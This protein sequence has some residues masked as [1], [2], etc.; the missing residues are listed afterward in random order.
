MLEIQALTYN[1]LP[2]VVPVAGMIPIDGG[3]VGRGRENAV[4]LPDPMRL[5][6]RQHLQFTLE[7]KNSYRISNISS[8]NLVYVNDQELEPGEGCPVQ[9]QDKIIIGGYVLRVSYAA[10][11]KEEL[12]GS[13]PMAA[14][15]TGIDDPLAEPMS[16]DFLSSLLA[17]GSMP[18][19]KPSAA[20][21]E[22][23]PDDPFAHSA[24]PMS[25][26]DPMLALNERGVD[27]GSFEDK[28]DEL[29]NGENAN[30][31]AD[32][33]LRDPLSG[34]VEGVLNG[35]SLDPLS[36]FG[37]DYG[38]GLDDILQSGKKTKAP[39]N[40]GGMDVN[41]GSELDGLF[42]LP[43][44]G[45]G[46][47]RDST[48]DPGASVNTALLDGGDQFIV[49]F[50]ASA[51][52]DLLDLENAEA[53]E[54]NAMNDLTATQVPVGRNEAL[55]P[56]DAL[57]SVSNGNEVPQQDMAAISL[58]SE[59]EQ[60]SSPMP[61]AVAQPPATAGK[62]ILPDDLDQLIA[63]LNPVPD[64][65]PVADASSGM[66]QAPR[67]DS[68]VEA[69]AATTPSATPFPAPSAMSA[70][71]AVSGAEHAET[72]RQPLPAA[73]N[74]A[75]ARQTAQELFQAF[76]EGLGIEALPD[77]DALDKDFM[78]LAGRLLRSYAQGTVDLMAGRAIVKQ[79]VRAN[80]TLIAPERNNPLKFSPDGEV[81]LMYLLGRQFP[82]FME[83]VE[84]VQYAFTDLRAHQIGIVSGMRSALNHVL[85][86]FDPTVID[87]EAS[88]AGLIDSMLSV[89]RKARLW[90]A[91]GRYFQTTREDAEDH[92]QEFFGSTFLEAYENA[93]STVQNGGGD[94]DKS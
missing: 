84:A 41:H 55:L 45:M 83:P 71:P 9:D 19:A 47:G 92:F 77:R 39:S 18:D 63:G 49:N 66:R 51:D 91:Y 25:S 62:A 81:A 2:P 60:P 14:M 46:Q 88:R 8:A 90:E 29:I 12:P 80:V 48:A 75:V 36:M 85:D 69:P 87:N 23:D 27:L 34:S 24:R 28:G 56:D 37:N 22:V 53:P 50:G 30:G 17:P 52:N 35:S 13:L 42:R 3:T 1:D 68:V 32:E 15:A 61:D 26:T 79:A 82:G 70:A 94:R 59:Q 86:R 31:M 54:N 44:P 7:S 11:Q 78:R 10:S 20:R 21:M 16:D 58:P 89:G 76:A 57:S 33:L 74:E 93:I 4:I 38:E 72:L 6:S 73:N 67:I 43:E 64:A 5:V 40:M 65:S